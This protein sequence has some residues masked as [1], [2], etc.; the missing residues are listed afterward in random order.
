MH[1]FTIILIVC[2]ILVFINYIYNNKHK[3]N[4]NQ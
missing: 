1:I 4:G 3:N 2:Y